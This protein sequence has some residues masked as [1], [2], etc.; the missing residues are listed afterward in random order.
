[1]SFYK[2]VWVI[3]VITISVQA[4]E[5][6]LIKGSDSIQVKHIYPLDGG[7]EGFI[8]GNDIGLFYIDKSGENKYEISNKPVN[9]LSFSMEDFMFSDTNKIYVAVGNGSESDEILGGIDELDV[10]PYVNFKKQFSIQGAK[11]I[12]V[13][14]RELF[15][16][17]DSDA[18]ISTISE[19]NSLSIPKKQIIP[20]LPNGESPLY[21]AFCFKNSKFYAGGNKSVLSLSNDT[22][23]K[24]Y[25]ITT[26]TFGEIHLAGFWTPTLFM[27]SDSTLY[28][29]GPKHNTL[30]STPD[31]KRVEAF[32]VLPA[33]WNSNSTDESPAIGTDS[34]VFYLDMVSNSFERVGSQITDV[35]TLFYSSSDTLLYA[36]TEDGIYTYNFNESTPVKASKSLKTDINRVTF[37]NSTIN[38]ASSNLKNGEA[39]VMCFNYS[40]RLLFEKHIQVN[41]QRTTVNIDQFH[42]ANNFY[43]LKISQNGET[44][45][46]PSLKK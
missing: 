38:I 21:S 4:A 45:S 41:Q 7:N 23:Y 35:R 17:S 13:S 19:D 2:C 36:G 11:K 18:W 12:A 31:K 43:V 32:A 33:F 46:I 28:Y 44:F 9:D 24:A 5:W 34:G 15:I 6:S 26:H 22:L 25:D 14:D 27:G 39:K 29:K 10:P 40:G 42:L 37:S 30:I 8:I 3:L 20:E 16:C 1:M